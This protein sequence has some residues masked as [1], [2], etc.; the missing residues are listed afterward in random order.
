M[1]ESVHE[2]CLR[3]NIELTR[4]RPYRRTTSI[5]RAKN[6][7]IVR[8]IVGYRRFEGLRAT[9]EL[10][11]LYSSMRLFVNFFQPSFKLKEKHRDG[12]R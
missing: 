12:A 4:C 9:R 6:G 5:C 10:A 7:A 11:K 1:N 3:D 2:Y 8:K